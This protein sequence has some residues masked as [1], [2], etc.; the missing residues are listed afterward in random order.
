MPTSTHCSQPAPRIGAKTPAVGPLRRTWSHGPTI[1]S[2]VAPGLEDR[3]ARAR[4]LGH[5]PQGFGQPLE[6][7]FQSSAEAA[8]GE[9]LS[10][11]RVRRGVEAD[12]GSD[13]A[14]AR[15]E[16]IHLDRRVDPPQTPAGRWVLGHE[17]AHVVQ[18]RRGR[19]RATRRDGGHAV[20]DDPRLEG[21]A[22]AVA[23]RLA[24]AP[25]GARPAAE[26]GAGPPA[27]PVTAVAPPAVSPVSQGFFGALRRAA[28]AAGRWAGGLWNR[29]RAWM[30]PR[31]RPAA[32]PPAE[33]EPLVEAPHNEPAPVEPPPEIQADPIVAPGAHRDEAAPAPMIFPDAAELARMHKPQKQ[34]RSADSSAASASSTVTLTPAQRRTIATKAIANSD[35]KSHPLHALAAERPAARNQ[36]NR[37][38]SRQRAIARTLSQAESRVQREQEKEGTKKV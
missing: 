14:V 7:A 32:E 9:D 15:G 8:L 38:R 19:V 34:R 12:S 1:A 20:N 29:F 11:V 24:R 6:P 36:S 5:R 23:E 21:E 3:L 33:M 18:Q 22:D 26:P 31:R 35:A 30:Q 25:A 13:L 10:S 27:A 16:E 2:P 17:L 37:E 4:T 28:G